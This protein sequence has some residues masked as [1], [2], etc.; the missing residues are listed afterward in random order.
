MTFRFNDEK[1]IKVPFSNLVLQS[2]QDP[3]TGKAI[4]LFG[5]LP[6]E[7]IILGDNFL[8]SSYSVFNLD[9]KTISIA[10]LK[11]TNDEDIEVIN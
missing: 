4:C 6:S 11:Q 10:Q 7:D 3:N 5:V 8:R 2:G 1:D 9:D